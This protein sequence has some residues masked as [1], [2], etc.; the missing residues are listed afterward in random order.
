VKLVSL[1]SHPSDCAHRASSGIKR[2]SP[3]HSSFSLGRRIEDEGKRRLRQPVAQD[4]F[5]TFLSPHP[6]PLPRGEG[7]TIGARKNANPSMSTKA[8]RTASFSSGRRIENE[9]KS[10]LRQSV[11]HD[12]FV[13]FVP[14]HP[15]PLPQ[16]EG[17]E[18]IATHNS[19]CPSFLNN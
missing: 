16:G 8:Q 9:G 10:T 7:G 4:S 3:P 12:F 1:V 19:F 11:A 5:V 6:C 2:G 14:P 13:A 15:S 17:G 18:I